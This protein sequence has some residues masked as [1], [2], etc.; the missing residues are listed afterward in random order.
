MRARARVR[1]GALVFDHGGAEMPVQYMYLSS[2]L[3]TLFPQSGV[4]PSPSQGELF[5][6]SLKVVSYR[7]D[8]VYHFSCFHSP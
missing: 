7:R 1:V 3:P 4:P 6:L 2:G 5:W 8:N